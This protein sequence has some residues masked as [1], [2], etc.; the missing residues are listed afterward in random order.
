MTED[1]FKLAF[2]NVVTRCFGWSLPGTSVVPFADCLNH[3]I[4]DSQYEMWNAKLHTLAKEL[5]DKES[6]GIRGKTYPTHSKMRI[7]YD[8]Y[9]KSKETAKELEKKEEEKEEKPQETEN[10]EPLVHVEKN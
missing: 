10:G 8:N 4:I 5:P 6:M 1:I 7:N 2:T 3:F 9:W